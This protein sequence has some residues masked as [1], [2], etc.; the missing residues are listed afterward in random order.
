[1]D[2]MF[3]S[4]ELQGGGGCHQRLIGIKVRTKLLPPPWSHEMSTLWWVTVDVWNS[5]GCSLFTFFF[6][7]FGKPFAT[8]YSAM[9]FGIVFFVLFFSVCQSYSSKTYFR[10]L[11]GYGNV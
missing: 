8:M 10:L 11:I 9:F 2:A 7:F 4:E 3:G 6:F 5:M 1:M